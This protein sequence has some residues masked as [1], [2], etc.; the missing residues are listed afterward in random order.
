MKYLHEFRDPVLARRLLTEI[1][2]SVSEPRVLMEVCGGQTHSLLRHGIEAELQG[3]VELIHGPGC[4]VCVTPAADID[5]AQALALRPE[6]LL[7]SFGDM[8]RVPGSRRSL[9]DVRGEGGQVRI[10]YSPLDAVELARKSPDRQ[11]VFFAVGFETTAPATALAVLQAAQLE[12][13]NFCLLVSHVRVLPAMEALMQDP[14]CRV[15]G[16]LA[17]G[18]VCTVTGFA[19]YGAFVRRYRVPVVVTGFEPVDLLQGI[20][21]CVNQLEC[22]Q[23]EVANR[24]AR[25][26]RRDGNMAA[27]DVVQQV[28]EVADTP[29][30]GLG[31]IPAGG[32]RLRSEFARYDASCKFPELAAVH[33]PQPMARVTADQGCVAAA[34]GLPVIPSGDAMGSCSNGGSYTECRSGEVLTGRIKPVECAAFGSRCTPDSPL[35]APMVSAEGAC[36]AYYR[37]QAVE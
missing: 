12:L 28:Y 19:E 37:Y 1:R 33:S 4:P 30:R 31:V 36:A 35:G 16:F 15:Q 21:E 20:L 23:F 25:S 17:A 6:V 14:D 3:V 29:W 34:T 27:A 13:D 8:L 2:Q 22:G 32:Y 18:H 9:L 5:M 24:Y 26:V 10:V 11:V 7:A